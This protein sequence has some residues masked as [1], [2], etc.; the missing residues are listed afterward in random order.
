MERLPWEGLRGRERADL[1]V[2]LMPVGS[3]CFAE[4]V[5]N[6]CGFV[7]SH[8]WRL[9]SGQRILNTFAIVIRRD[10]HGP[11]TALRQ[12]EAGKGRHEP[13]L[14]RSRQGW[15][16]AG[17]A[18]VIKTLCVQPFWLSRFEPRLAQ[19]DLIESRTFLLSFKLI[20]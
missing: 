13:G 5:A 15:R 1:G 17:A 18:W 8:S 4:S 19:P 2:A 10:C 7:G 3:L 16:E 9:R 6:C 11:A 14:G 20:L 12:A